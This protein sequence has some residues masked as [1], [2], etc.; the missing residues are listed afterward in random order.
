MISS[1]EE[2]RL[3]EVIPVH[4]TMLKEKADRSKQANNSLGGKIQSDTMRNRKNQSREH[5][6]DESV[7]VRRSDIDW[8]Q[9][10]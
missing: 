4:E 6:S 7:T 9:I 8:N 2:I 1:F 5:N 3:W 10:N